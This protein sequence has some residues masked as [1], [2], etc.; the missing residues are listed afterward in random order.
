MIPVEEGAAAIAILVPLLVACIVGLLITPFM[1][2]VALRFNCM[3]HPVDR[4]V[5][6][7]PIPFLGG[8]A[9]YLAFLVSTLVFLDISEPTVRGIL[10]GGGVIVLLGVLD[11]LYRL[12]AWM[13]FAGQVGAAMILVTYGIRIDRL[14]HPAGGFFYFNGW[15]VPFTLLWVV[16]FTN[17]LN[18]I[19][20]LDGLAAGVAAIASTVLLV[21]G[22]QTGQPQVALLIAAILAGSALGFLP[23]NFNPARIFMGDAGAMFLGY[24]LAAIS[25]SGTLK[26]TAAI[27]LGIPVLA[28]GLPVMDA[29]LAVVRRYR[30]GQAFYE[31][32]TGHLHHRLI[33]MGMTQREAVVLMYCISGWMGIGAL[34]LSSLRA[35]PGLGVF[36]FVFASFYLGAR[37]FG[38]LDVERREEI[39]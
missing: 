27:A 5:H 20:G 35:G 1:R 10:L 17:A 13:K 11:D 32:D 24:T 21:V 22:I 7:A 39:R 3:D 23:Y 14:S 29:A 16:A 26:S 37:R 34:A 25:I 33:Q 19:D 6:C 12:P 28:M 18:F 15:A 31:A 2:R 9:I 4:S 30:N 8:V 38:I 36:A